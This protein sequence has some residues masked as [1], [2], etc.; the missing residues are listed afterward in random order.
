MLS[1]FEGVQYIVG[2]GAE[3]SG[4]HWDGFGFE[5]TV[6]LW[7]SDSFAAIVTHWEK[8]LDSDWLRDSDS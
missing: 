8:L 5:V 7:V 1:T 4:V 6:H 3:L 2:G